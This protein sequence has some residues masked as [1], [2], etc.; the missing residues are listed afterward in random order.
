ML[1]LLDGAK[2][3]EVVLVI[4]TVPSSKAVDAGVKGAQFQG[5]GY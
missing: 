4:M 1:T 3:D 5:G 2:E